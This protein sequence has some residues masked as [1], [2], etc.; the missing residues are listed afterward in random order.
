MRCG[1][2]PDG[3]SARR[4]SGRLKNFQMEAAVNVDH[5]ASAEWEEALS[6]CRNSFADIFGRSPAFDGGEA[7]CD[8]RIIFLLHAAGHICSDNAGANFVNINAM[9]SEAGGEQRRNHRESRFG[10]TIIASID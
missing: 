1:C 9:F 7:P 4:E 3:R 10:H 8:E 2:W 6:D 5:F